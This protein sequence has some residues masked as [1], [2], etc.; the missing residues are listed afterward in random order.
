LPWVAAVNVAR[1][2]PGR[3]VIHLYERT[4]LAKWNQDDLVTPDGIIFTPSANDT[5]P[6]LP[7]LYGPPAEVGYVVQMY[8]AFSAQLA[9]LQLQVSEVHL[10]QR[11]SWDLCLSNGMIVKLG[12]TQMNQRLAQFIRVYPQVFANSTQQAVY[13]DLRYGHGMAVRWATA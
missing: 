12:R 3:I 2:W 1:A 7:H 11:L 9:P 5:L 8:Q 6:V 13:V 4:P 10:S